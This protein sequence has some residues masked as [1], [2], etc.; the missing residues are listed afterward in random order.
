MQAGSW[1][2]DADVRRGIVASAEISAAASAAAA[3]AVVV[4]VVVVVVVIVA[5]TS[6][7][8]RGIQMRCTYTLQK[9]DCR[10]TDTH[11]PVSSPSP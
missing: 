10:H 8:G 7:C 4:V 2:A 1:E 5:V 3:V 6:R 9:H 11:P